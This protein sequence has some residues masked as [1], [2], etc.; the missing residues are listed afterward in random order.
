MKKEL[1]PL[2]IGGI[3]VVVV[4]LAIG[5]GVN[6]VNNSSGGKE[7]PELAQKQLEFERSKRPGGDGNAVP[8]HVPAPASSFSPGRESEMAARQQTGGN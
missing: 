1:S 3:L 6:F 4:A 2:A 7:D 5:L 8:A